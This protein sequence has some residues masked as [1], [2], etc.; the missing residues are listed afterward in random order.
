MECARRQGQT[1]GLLSQ[2]L[3]QL[4]MAVALVD[5]TVSGEEVNVVLAFGIPDIDTLSAGEDDG[6][7]VV[8]VGCELILGSDRG[9]GRGRME[10]RVQSGSA[11][12]GNVL[13]CVRRHVEVVL[14]VKGGG[15]VRWL[16]KGKGG[17]RRRESEVCQEEW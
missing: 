14:V 7:W 13:V 15:S 16:N 4:W 10:M 3:D 8:V 2:G 12:D 6:K 17:R 9:L 1:A 5:S 11:I